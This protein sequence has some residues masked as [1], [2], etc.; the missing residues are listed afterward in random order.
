MNNVIFLK[1]NDI[2]L[3]QGCCIQLHHVDFDVV[4]GTLVGYSDNGLEVLSL[5]GMVYFCE[6][7]SILEL[8]KIA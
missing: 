5:N 1:F 3:S 2:L 6:F 8:E 4:L 7:S